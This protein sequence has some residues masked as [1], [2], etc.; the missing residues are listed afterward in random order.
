MKQFTLDDY[1]HHYEHNYPHIFNP[2]LR[3]FSY[4]AKL[5]TLKRK[6]NEFLFRCE[7][8][9]K[10]KV[11]VGLELCSPEMFRVR[12]T[13]RN[14][15]NVDNFPM[16]VK[17]DWKPVFFQMEKN[18]Y[19]VIITSSSLQIKI[20][21]NPW[22]IKVYDKSGNLVLEEQSNGID[23]LQKHL[24]C[25][26]GFA[27]TLDK[28][29]KPSV[30]ES[31]TLHPEEQLFG[32]GEKYSELN[33]RGKR[34]VSWNVDTA[35]TVTDR[36][37]KNIPLLLSTRGYG[38]YINNTAKI[39]Y[40]LGSES[41]IASSFAVEDD[42]LDYYVIYGPTFKQILYHYTELTGRAPVPPKWSF[43]LWMSKCGYRNRQEVEHIAKTLRKKRIPCDV[44]HIDPWWMKEGHFCDFEWDTDAFP[45]PV[46]ML[47][48]LKEQGFKVSL[49]EQPYVPK[50]S[51]MFEEGKKHG[52]FI[53]DKKGNIYPFRD[54]MNPVSALVDFTNPEAVKWYQ[55]KHQKIL[56]MGISAFKTDMSEAVPEDA[57]FYNGL[58]GAK[59]HNLYSLL[60]N[61]TVYE[62]GARFPRPIIPAFAG[63]T[64]F[65]R[66]RES[67]RE[68]LPLPP[69][70]ALVWGRSG[71]AG[72]QRY[73]VNWS[74]DSN[75]TWLDMSCNLRAGL[76]FGLSGVPFWSCD[77]G[78]FIGNPS[79][80]LFIRWA[81]FGLFTSHARCHGATPREPWQFG[82]QAEQIFRRFVNLRYR[83]IPYLYT[84]AHLAHRT[85]LP[86]IRPLVLEYQ[87]DPNVYHQDLEYLF[88]EQFLVA[89]ILDET[90]QRT[91][92]LPAGEWLDYWTKKVYSGNQ[93][94]HY[95]APLSR[96]PLFIKQDSIIPMGPKMNYIGE[97]P[98]NPITIDIYLKNKA[99]FTLINDQE[100]IKFFGIREKNQVKFTITKSQKDYLLN[101]NA[102]SQPK[103]VLCNGKPIPKAT[104]NKAFSNLH[105]TWKM[106]INSL[107]I[108]LFNSYS[109]STDLILSFY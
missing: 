78:G 83:L 7:T 49:W 66:K 5:L 51:K 70:T 34:F 89:P 87:D 41:Y 77:I 76:N 91:I 14:K 46:E 92:Y 33:K 102:C 67:G 2:R 99:E 48:N 85:G 29:K 53:K 16:V 1:L 42:Q 98:F 103:K 72:T 25:P 79:P 71:Y 75:S 31:F 73:P 6:G 45:N 74:G 95:T 20:N 44:I 22:Q 61:R 38:I 93:H 26:L 30:Y 80:E 18:R 94:I 88:G 35:T 59:M 19:E 68:T 9:D 62:V 108:K 54:F 69:E 21:K 50:N 65:P 13:A 23:G 84:Y 47:R 40:E 105:L 60:Y 39:T 106:G 11:L 96:L 56:E 100:E 57:V 32:L 4:T 24:V 55:A 28:D 27:T 97:K 36:A 12:L 10:K 3:T 82:K 101:F 63:M 104:T 17:K 64:S 107:Q 15:F 90:N 58:T 86:V 43:G 8:N 52:Y 37:Y 81:Q 109:S